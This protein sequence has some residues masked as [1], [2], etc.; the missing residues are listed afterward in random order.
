MNHYLKVESWGYSLWRDGKQ[1][2]AAAGLPWGF[3][4]ARELN[5]ADRRIL[6]KHRIVRLS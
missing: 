2:G 1:Y 4:H 5:V 6:R 3:L